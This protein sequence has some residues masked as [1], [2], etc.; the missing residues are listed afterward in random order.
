MSCDVTKC[1]EVRMVHKLLSEPVV[2]VVVVVKLLDD[3]VEMCGVGVGGV[4]RTIIMSYS[5]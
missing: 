3:T 2:V 1:H 4:L 5:S